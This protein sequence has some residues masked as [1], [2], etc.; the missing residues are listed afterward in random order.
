M[1]SSGARAGAGKRARL[2]AHAIMEFGREDG[3]RRR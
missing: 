2:E 1:G 3:G